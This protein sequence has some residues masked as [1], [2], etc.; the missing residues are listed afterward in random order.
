MQLDAIATGI[1]SL[2]LELN[3]GTNLYFFSRKGRSSHLPTVTLLRIIS[4]LSVP[5]RQLLLRLPTSLL[6]PMVRRAGVRTR[7]ERILR[8]ILIRD[9]YDPASWVE[10][11]DTTE[12]RRAWDLLTLTRLLPCLRYCSTCSSWS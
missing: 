5:P 11:A 3:N 4:Q 12:P 7:P 2:S 1:F 9:Y 10:L 6:T 8:D